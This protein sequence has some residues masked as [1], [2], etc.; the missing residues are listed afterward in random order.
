MARSYEIVYRGYDPVDLEL[1][2]AQLRAAAVPYVRLGRGNAAM[3]GVGNY[4]V[5][6]LIEVAAEHV[7][8]ARALVS[9]ARGDDDEADDAEL[10][11]SGAGHM[12]PGLGPRWSLS[13]AVQHMTAFGLLLGIALLCAAVFQA[14]YCSTSPR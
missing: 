11:D 14:A 8:E 4:I 9:A 1:V 12:P 10:D 13:S 2:E 7:D 3:L 5:E 6:Q